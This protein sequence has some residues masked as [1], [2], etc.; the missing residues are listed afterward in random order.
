[1]PRTSAMSGKSALL[2]RATRG[3]A[4]LAGATIVLSFLTFLVG[5]SALAGPAG[6]PPGPVQPAVP[7]ATPGR[8]VVHDGIDLS[9]NDIV[10]GLDQASR[11]TPG[12]ISSP[13]LRALR[14]ALI[15]QGQNLQ[16]MDKSDQLFPSVLTQ[17][18]LKVIEEARRG[19]ALKVR[20]GKGRPSR[21]GQDPLVD[22]VVELLEKKS[23]AHGKGTGS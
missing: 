8:P 2:G 11:A 15:R 16:M 10:E 23:R 13:Q 6:A 9:A 21:P 7:G 14:T 18:Q 20:L 12:T 3:R 17:A 1:M 5:R 4:W 19:D 22:R